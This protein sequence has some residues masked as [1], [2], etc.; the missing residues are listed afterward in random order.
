MFLKP[1]NVSA[2]TNMTNGRLAWFKGLEYFKRQLLYQLPAPLSNQSLGER[3]DEKKKR[4]ADKRK[5]HI[6]S[7]NQMIK[8]GKNQMI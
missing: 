4:S 2:V 7:K 1:D 6:R 8:T 3:S 5:N